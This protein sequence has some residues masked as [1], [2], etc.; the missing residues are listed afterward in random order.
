MGTR[1]RKLV[2]SLALIAFVLIYALVAM[3]VAQGRI[4]EAPAWLQLVLYAALGLAWIVPAMAIIRWMETGRI[5][6]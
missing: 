3:A 6:G 2:G 5:R 4:T 1:L